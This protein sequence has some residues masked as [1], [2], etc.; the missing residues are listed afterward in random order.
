[1]CFAPSLAMQEPEHLV[2]APQSYSYSYCDCGM[3]MKV[4][5][6]GFQ[7]RDLLR[8]AGAPGFVIS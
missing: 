5:Q 7:E 3:H 8:S 1:M 6:N 2:H 4:Q